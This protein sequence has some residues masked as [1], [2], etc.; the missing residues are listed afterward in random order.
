MIAQMI[1]ESIP[2]HA[3]CSLSGT[4]MKD[5]RIRTMRCE[6]GYV[7]DRDRNAAMNIKKEGLRIM[8]STA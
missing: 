2:F 3:V 8:N 4:E 5:L 6:C 1:R 7:M